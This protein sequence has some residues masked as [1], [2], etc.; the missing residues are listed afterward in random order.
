MID[1]AIMATRQL[2]KRQLTWLRSWKELE[3]LPVDQQGRAGLRPGD[4]LLEE[5]LKR[6]ATARI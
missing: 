6:L 3:W 4:D 1:R 5:A 2:A